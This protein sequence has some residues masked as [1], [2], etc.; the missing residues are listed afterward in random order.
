MKDNRE[1]LL[2]GSFCN[3]LPE[4][5]AGKFWEMERRLTFGLEIKEHNNQWEKNGRK[6]GSMS[7][8]IGP[9]VFLQMCSQNTERINKYLRFPKSRCE[10]ISVS[11]AV[12]RNMLYR[13]HCLLLRIVS[14]DCCQYKPLFLR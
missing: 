13:C 3:H 5:D 2:T 7:P 8:A 11:F 12:S 4:I 14:P 6:T 9:F 10:K 1:P